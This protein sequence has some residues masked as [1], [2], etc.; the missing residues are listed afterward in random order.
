MPNYVQ[1][2][3]AIEANNP[4]RLM[5]V[6]GKISN[7]REERPIDFNKVIPCPDELNDSE[8]HC[9]GGGE[10]KAKERD[11]KRKL[12]KEKHGFCNSIDFST[13]MWG[14]KWNALE[15]V[16]GGVQREGDGWVSIYKF[17]T[18]WSPPL[19]VIIKLS[20]MYPDCKFNLYCV[21]ECGNFDPV[22]YEIM[23][24]EVAKQATFVPEDFS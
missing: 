22:H 17:Q 24:G 23:N 6:M 18:A 13:E 11:E 2:D 15:T 12:M 19:P 16:A 21:E 7:S 5:A 14:T 10:A 20:S 8:L 4:I 3:L 1:N 9:Y